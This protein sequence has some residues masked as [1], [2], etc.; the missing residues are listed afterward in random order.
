MENREEALSFVEKEL[1]IKLR[2]VKKKSNELVFARAV[3]Y[4]I[5]KH[6]LGL[7]YMATGELVNKNHATV[8]HSYR[9]IL[10]YIKKINPYRSLIERIDIM[11]ASIEEQKRFDDQENIDAEKV[12]LKVNLKNKIIENE[13]LLLKIES[14][15]RKIDTLQVKYGFLDSKKDL[16]DIVDRIPKYKREEMLEKMLTAARTVYNA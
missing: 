2:K 5:C 3:Y 10:P 11:F 6:H 13:Q 7:S 8:I 4:Y 9:H 14:L 16:K 1:K 12:M 15:N